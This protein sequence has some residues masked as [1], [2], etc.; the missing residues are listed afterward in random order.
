[1]LHEVS[2]ACFLALNHF[3][4]HKSKSSPYELFKGNSLPLEFFKPLGSLVL[5][6]LLPPK[7][8]PKLFPKGEIGRLVGYNDDL[9]SFK[10]LAPSGKILSTKHVKF[11]DLNP[12]ADSPHKNSSDLV[13]NL[14]SEIVDNSPAEASQPSENVSQDSSS[15]PSSP[16]QSENTPRYQLRPRTDA[17]RP[18]EYSHFTFEPKS[19]KQAISCEEKSEWKL[20]IDDEISN[21]ENQEVWEDCHVTPKSSCLHTTWFFKVKPATESSPEKKKARLCKQGFEQTYN[22]D[23]FENF[24]PTGKFSSLLAL[25]TLAVHKKL[26]LQQFDV[27]GAFLYAPLDEDIF[28]LNPLGSKRSF[29]YLKL[30]KSIYR[31]KQAPLNWYMTLTSWLKTIGYTESSLDPCLFFYHNKSSFL[32]FHV[33]DLVVAGETDWFEDE[34]L[35]RFPNSSAH[36]PDTLL[37]MKIDIQDCLILLSQESLI[38]KGLKL[39]GFDNLLPVKTP[40]PPGSSP[41]KASKSEISEFK[42]LKVNY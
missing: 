4:S 41:T 27:K 25:L 34:F 14:E 17:I 11:V 13:L 6:L 21:L 1:M 26:K 2:R 9:R 22:L 12:K 39:I 24:A 29:K 28:I 42:K 8:G 5:Y 16:T 36:P 33:D 40:L 20:A 15:R 23:Y 19:F 32:F 35:R 30:K 31:L 38:E 7:P 18:C 37:G 10:I 3:P